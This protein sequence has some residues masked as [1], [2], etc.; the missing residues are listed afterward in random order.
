MSFQSRK[1]GGKIV[2][3]F[4]YKMDTMCCREIDD[5]IDELI[6]KYDCPVVFDL[7]GVEYVSS[8]FLR[9]CQRG[10]AAVGSENFEII[11]AD[12]AVKKVFE[13]SGMMNVLSIT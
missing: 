7:T 11:N 4:S 10:A 13:I 2:Y 1:E 8:S 12:P 3:T 9:I 5:T 6:E